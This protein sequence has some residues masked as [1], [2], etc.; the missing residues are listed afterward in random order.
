[1]LF[2][3]CIITINKTAL[4]SGYNCF[5]H[6]SGHQCLESQDLEHPGIYKTQEECFEACHIDN[7]T[8]TTQQN[9]D[10]TSEER[11]ESSLE[12]KKEKAQDFLDDIKEIQAQ[13]NPDMVKKISFSGNILEKIFNFFY[14]I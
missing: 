4:A 14:F 13:P 3:I 2:F 9:I 8:V 1:L 7:P 6:I 5:L 10:N 11:L 12:S